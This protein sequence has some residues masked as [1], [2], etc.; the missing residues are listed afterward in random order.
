MPRGKDQPAL[1]GLTD[2]DQ[3]AGFGASAFRAPEDTPSGFAVRTRSAR[4]LREAVRTNA[5]RTPG[6]YG[7]LGP[8]GHV[9]YVGKAKNLRSRLLS[10]FR[11]DSRHPKAGKIID[12]TATLVWEHLPDELNALLRELELIR[13][14]RPRYNVLGQPGRQRYVYLCLGRGPGVLAYLSREATGKEAAVYGPFVG[15]GRIQDAVR[16]LNYEFKLRDCPNTVPMRFAD[17][18]ELFAEDRSAA[19]LRYELGTCL[20]PCGGFCTAAD[21]GARVRAAKAFL[22]GRDSATLK[23]IEAEMAKASAGLKFEQAAVLR[24]RWEALSRLNDRLLFLRSARKNHSFVYP[25]AGCDN[26]T[27]WYMIHG[28]E[29]RVVVR[30][31]DTPASAAAAK[32]AAEAVF[33]QPYSVDATLRRCVDSV[34]IVTSWFRGNAGERA[35]LLTATEAVGRC[36]G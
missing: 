32:A 8:K 4:K 33:A 2:A 7:M 1:P 23:A 15:R 18:S 25:L 26:L 17:Q 16:R 12:H 3:F 10:Y 21:Y 9:I 30:E 22:D 36:G 34:L 14:F 13:R 29:V 35:K 5:P 31:P 19:C 11:T 28:G 20:G 6:V 27:R 24:D